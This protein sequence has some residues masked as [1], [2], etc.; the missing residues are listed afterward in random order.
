MRHR[1][2]LAATYQGLIFLGFIGCVVL[3]LL[4]WMMFTHRSQCEPLLQVALELFLS[5]RSLYVYDP[6]YYYLY[7]GLS[8]VL[9]VFWSASFVAA[10]LR[11]PREDQHVD[12]ALKSKLIPSA[13]GAP[14][15]PT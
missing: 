1:K 12:A 11:K 3:A 13:R 2:P 14:L 10:I 15:D 7:A 8:A 6:A 5:R 4:S 9:S